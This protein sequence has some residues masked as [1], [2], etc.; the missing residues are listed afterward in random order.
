MRSKRF[1]YELNE[2]YLLTDDI[3]NKITKDRVSETKVNFYIYDIIEIT[4]EL[5][6]NNCY[7]YIVKNNAT[8]LNKDELYHLATTIALYESIK[9]YKAEIEVHFL[10]YWF[11]VMNRVFNKEWLR[12]RTQKEKFNHSLYSLNEFDSVGD[13]TE[14]L[15]NNDF[16]YKCIDEFT[17][18]DK[19]GELVKSELNGTREERRKAKIDFLGVAEYGNRE[20]KIVQ[21]TKQRFAEYLKEEYKKVS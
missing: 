10:Y 3:I 2:L 12:L 18:Q 8:E 19:Y 1:T 13:F 15:V 7:R 16:I 17:K 4:K 6:M 14:E 9:S 20:R 11:K 21:R 5:I